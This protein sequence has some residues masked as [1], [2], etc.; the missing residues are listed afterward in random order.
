MLFFKSRSI[1]MFFRVRSTLKKMFEKGRTLFSRSKY[2]LLSLFPSQNILVVQ[3]A[4]DMFSII[5]RAIDKKT[6]RTACAVGRFT[7]IFSPTLNPCRIEFT[8]SL[9]KVSC[10][11]VLKAG[12]IVESLIANAL[13]TFY[14]K[15]KQSRRWTTLLF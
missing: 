2:L 13:P 14:W 9:Q 15:Q 11:T 5:S 6:V 12:Q 3:L 10:I 1:F 8:S 7:S 4:Q